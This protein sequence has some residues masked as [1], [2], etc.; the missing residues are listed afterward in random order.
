MVDHQAEKLQ[1]LSNRLQKELNIET[2]PITLDLSTENASDEI[3]NGL[4]TLDCRLLVYNAAFSIIKPFV[5]L[6][7]DD[8]NGFTDINIKTQMGLVHSFSKRLVEDDKGGGIILMSSL[9]GVLGMQLVAPYAATKAFTW[10]LAE[11]LHHELKPHNIDIMACIAGATASPAYLKTDP[12]Y[13]KLKPQVMHP[14]A[15]AE[16]ALK[17]LGKKT[18]FIPGFSNRFNYF[19]LTKLLPRRLASRIANNTMKKM[20]S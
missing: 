10:N 12:K 19:I 9:A 20:Y 14:D 1:E 4:D 17:K 6:S 13:G 2:I 16:A 15:V 5:S 18:L 11:A 3:M 7:K 8:L